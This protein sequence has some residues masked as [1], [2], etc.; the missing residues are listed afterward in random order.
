[1]VFL[2]KSQFISNEKEKNKNKNKTCQPRFPAQL[3]FKSEEEIKK[4]TDNQKLKEFL[5]T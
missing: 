4:L 5:T 2:E 3:S 1:M